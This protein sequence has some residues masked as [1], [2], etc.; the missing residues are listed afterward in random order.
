MKLLFLVALLLLLWAVL[1]SPFLLMLYFA[2]RFMRRRPI[3]SASVIVAVVAVFALLAAPVPTPIITVLLPHGFAMVDEAYYANATAGQ[4]V[5]SQLW[6]WI[7]SSLLTTFTITLAIC[8]RH[9][10]QPA[11]L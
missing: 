10:R 2:V 4:I 5:F 6:P 9:L 1:A 11:T 8:W 7:I 3:R